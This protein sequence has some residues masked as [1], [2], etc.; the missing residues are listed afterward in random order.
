M[1]FVFTVAKEIENTD[2]GQLCSVMQCVLMVLMA[3][4]LNLSLISEEQCEIVQMVD[5]GLKSSI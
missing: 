5:A 1:A 3:H 2:T 4:Q